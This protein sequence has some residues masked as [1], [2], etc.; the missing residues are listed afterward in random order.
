MA[1]IF[2]LQL[3]AMTFGSFDERSQSPGERGTHTLAEIETEQ[4][5]DDDRLHGEN[6]CEDGDLLLHFRRFVRIAR[7]VCQ[8]RQEGY[9]G[10]GNVPNVARG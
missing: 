3:F 2:E 6:R 4:L 5:E 10:F 9:D 1:K 8:L 7:R